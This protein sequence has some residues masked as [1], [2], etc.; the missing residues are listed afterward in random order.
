MTDVYQSG[1][2]YKTAQHIT[3][4]PLCIDQMSIICSQ[5]ST[6][7]RES[8]QGSNLQT[9]EQN[10]KFNK[11]AQMTRI[12]YFQEAF[13]GSFSFRRTRDMVIL[14]S[15]MWYFGFSAKI[16]K[17][18]FSGGQ[19]GHISAPDKARICHESYFKS[20]VSELSSGFSDFWFLSF[21]SQVRPYFSLVWQCAQLWTNNWHL[22]ILN[23][24]F[25]NTAHLF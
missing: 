3:Q 22:V 4:V 21:S 23:N 6:L 19:N 14:V 11:T 8:K 1:S 10:P 13:I 9:N 7:S 2:L 25:S 20:S 24:S 12:W 17:I 15:K 18:R 5:L 16:E